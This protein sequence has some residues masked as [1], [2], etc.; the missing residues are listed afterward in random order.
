MSV[1]DYFE[2]DMPAYV[3]RFR[4]RHGVMRYRFRRGSVCRYMGKDI[5]TPEFRELYRQLMD[6]TAASVTQPKRLVYFITDGLMVKIGVAKRPELR[7]REM[8]FGHPRLLR[9]LAT[10]EGDV[11]AERRY[12]QAFAAHRIRG[13]WFS[14]CPEIEAEIERINEALA[15]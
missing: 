3:S 6:G 14:L 13:E 10:T 5:A 11:P 15:A 8:Q 2:T 12:H 4:D 7:L 1:R 9:L